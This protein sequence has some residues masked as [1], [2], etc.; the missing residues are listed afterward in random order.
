MDSFDRLV[1]ID[2]L[3]HKVDILEEKLIDKDK[4]LTNLQ[5]EIKELNE[6]I[7]SLQVTVED[8]DSYIEELEDDLNEKEE[9]IIDLMN[10]DCI[11]VLQNK[12][13]NVVIELFS[14]KPDKF[15]I[16]NSIENFYLDIDD[17]SDIKY[18]VSEINVRH[19]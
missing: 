15:D 5:K 17:I 8:K 6:E 12:K 14:Q 19:N 2:D 10:K 13:D 11:Y 16:K 7:D 1:M 9:R 3:N 18:I 4:E